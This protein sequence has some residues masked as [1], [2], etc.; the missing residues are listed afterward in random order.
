MKAIFVH[1]KGSH[2]GNT[3]VFASKQISI[4]T[5]ASAD[6]HFDPLI[7]GNTSSRHA[8][9]QLKECDYVLRDKGSTKGTLVNNRPVNEIALKDGDL[10]EFGAG[11]PKVRFRVKTDESEVCK[12]WTEMIEDS[13]GMART[14][15]RGR[16]TTAT[17]FFRQLLWEAFTQS[18]HTFKVGASLVLFLICSGLIAYF[19]IQFV[20]LSKTAE[21]V[22]LLEIERSVAENIIKAYSGGVCLIQGTFYFFDEETGEPLMM[23]GGGQRGIHE[24]TGTGFL[25]GAD[26]LILTNRHIA[27]PWWEMEMSPYIHREPTIKPR[28]EVF[29]A[30]FPGIKEP[31]A[32]KVE[33]ISDEADVAL[34][35]ID[36]RGAKI[37]I[38]ELDVTGRGAVVGEPMILLGYPA[39]VNAIFAKTDPEI[40]KQ[41]FNL[42]FIPLVQE[43]S[44]WGLI[45]PLTTQGHLSDIMHNRIVYDAQTTAGGSGGPIFNNKGKVIGISYGIFPGF[46]GSNFGVP[47]SYGV[48]LVKVTSMRKKDK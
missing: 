2:R 46:R 40:V 27:E 11:G 43:L 36:M 16:I 29:R 18:S 25:V 8:E 14:S 23:M 6:L 33:K 26:G 31:F 7:D 24:Y 5:D 39:G 9:I 12:P 22:R 44:N 35:R 1:L 45:R 13:L 30:F 47:I 10:I 42:P 21:K 4:G 37:P 3:E 15:Q 34:L 32:L 38:L 28:F 48:D 19:Y 20:M 17:A 41:L